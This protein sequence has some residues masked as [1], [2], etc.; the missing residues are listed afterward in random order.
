MPSVSTADWVDAKARTRYHSTETKRTRQT[1]SFRTYRSVLKRSRLDQTVRSFFSMEASVVGCRWC[2]LRWVLNA[3]NARVLHSCQPPTYLLSPHPRH[4][5]YR[6]A[7]LEVLHLSTG[8]T[9]YSSI[10]VPASLDGVL[11]RPSIHAKAR[12][13]LKRQR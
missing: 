12:Y 5:A 2:K 11:L 9:S 6:S 7:A 8:T 4:L 3:A 13:L 10:I 1:D